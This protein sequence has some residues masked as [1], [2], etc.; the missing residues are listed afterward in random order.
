MTLK[1]K[2]E[3]I[4][5]VTIVCGL[6]FSPLSLPCAHADYPAKPIH[7]VAPYAPGGGTD[8]L[9]R[10]IAAIMGKEKII[11]SPII[12]ENRPGG[13]GAVGMDY[14]GAKKGNPYYLLTVV[15]T[16]ISN[17]ILKLTKVSY[18]DFTIIC[19]LAFDPN[20]I[21]VRTDYKYNTMEKLI[22]AAKKNPGKIRYGG[23]GATGSDRI[24]SLMLEKET[25]AKFN[26]IPFQSGGEVTTA[27]LGKHVDV[28]ANQMNESYSQIMAGKFKAL[29]ITSEERSKYMPDMPTVKE[30]G[31]NVIFGTMRGIAAP[32]DI[33]EEAR[34]FLEDAFT[35]L[36]ASER[37][38]KEYIQKFQLQRQFRNGAEFR[39]RII[40]TTERY[41]EIYKTLG[42]LK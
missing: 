9:A 29:A 13:G 18:K 31:A 38:Q 23:T 5:C 4:M 28:I 30:S 24:V 21:T 16:F 25:G 42:L 22:E 35:K 1:N 3:L 11:T 36:D 20:I 27:L 10:T 17:P 19:Q 8:I 37:W 34:K 33:S 6:I 15:T 40:E 12:V 7:I 14:V 39:K 2:I 32:A 41:K 26:F